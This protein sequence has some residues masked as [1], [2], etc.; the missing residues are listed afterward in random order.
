MT[1]VLDTSALIYWTLDPA[2]LTPAAANVIAQ[3]TRIVASSISI[4]EISIK[5]ERGKL[6]I[7]LTIEKYAQQ[8]QRVRSVE[9]L[10]VDTGIWLAN[11]SLNWAHRDPAD[12]TI[13]ATAAV[14]GAPLIA[15]DRMIRAF[16]AQTIW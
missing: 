16:Y 5:V 1:V 15:S 9:L 12:R 13:V 3:A 11:L 6:S 4:W 10:P 2:R 7:P 8:L 14:L